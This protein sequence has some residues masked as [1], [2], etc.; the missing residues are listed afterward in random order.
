MKQD[1]DKRS[2]SALPSGEAF[3][4]IIFIDDYQKRLETQ[5]E[6]AKETYQKKVNQILDD[7]IQE[8]ADAKISEYESD[9]SLKTTPIKEAAHDKTPPIE[10][11]LEKAEKA[12]REVAVKVKEDHKRAGLPMI[13]WK[14]GKVTKLFVTK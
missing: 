3:D 9:L 10:S 11:L 13:V 5:W 7:F 6:S 1:K 8:G 12:L 14:N 4:P 2:E